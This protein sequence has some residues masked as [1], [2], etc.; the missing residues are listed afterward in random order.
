MRIDVHNHYLPEPYVNLLLEWD[1][2]VGL[3]EE[4]GEYYMVH[5]KSGTASVREGQRIPLN[6][7]FTDVEARREWM[8]SHE[9]DRTLVSVSTP[10]PIADAFT[11]EQSTELVK[12]INDGYAAAED[13]HPDVFGGLGT[14]PLRDPEAAVEEVERIATSLDLAGIALPTSING[15]KISQPELAPA[16]EA[17][18]DHDITVFFHPHGNVLAETLDHNELFLSP[19]VVFPTETTLQIARLIYD[20]FF[21][22][23]DFDVVLSHMGGAILALA[24]RLDRARR[25]MDDPDEPPTRPIVSYL[26]EFYYDVISFHPP[27]LE[28]AIDTVG[29]DRLVF[30]TDYPFDEEDID[31]NI[32]H[33][34]A[35]VPRYS[36]RQRILSETAQDLFN[37]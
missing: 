7:G 34:E 26:E 18:E 21:D 11:V 19:L 30:G 28:T 31:T 13:D 8:Q 15:K 33:L 24:G 14:L 10:N 25:E 4:D 27:A 37:I 23:Y 17:I 9:I 2:P 12:A 3:V 5:E 22:T 29:I 36:D 32:G 35:V 6:V 20:G 1:T 16:F